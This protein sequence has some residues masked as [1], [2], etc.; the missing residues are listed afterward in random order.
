MHI[1]KSGGSTMNGLLKR[2]YR[3][4][5]IQLD[6]RDYHNN[7]TTVS[8]M[9]PAGRQICVSGHFDFGI[10]EYGP[11]DFA[12]F[13]ILR[14]PVSR[15]ISHYHFVKQHSD[16]YL[17]E[18]VVGQ[19]MS[20]EQYVER[21]LS[22][23]LD[24]GQVRMLAGA[25]GFHDSLTHRGT[26][27]SVAIGSCDEDL[28]EKSINHLDR[29]FP[30]FGLQDEFDKSILLF[31]RAFG[32]KKINYLSKKVNRKGGYRTDERLQK[33][34]EYHNPYDCRLYQY[35]QQK[36]QAAISQHK[37]YLRWG[38]RRLWWENIWL[39]SRTQIQGW[40]NQVK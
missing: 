7:H 39:E 35:A 21:K 28:L 11:A 33:L 32:W 18:R 16:H 40:I 4:R 12:Y 37:R 14:S 15:L 17:H 27:T 13:T 22:T 6:Y 36:L 8:Q 30:V 9:Q 29:Y 1:P 5:L 26:P 24:N 2:N 20:L 3:Q 10:H 19:Q 23:E 25:G 31:S 34:I 38:T